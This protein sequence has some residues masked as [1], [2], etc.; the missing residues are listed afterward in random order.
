VAQL[1]SLGGIA[2]MTKSDFISRQTALKSYALKLA[3]TH[4]AGLACFILWPEKKGPDGLDHLFVFCFFSYL[5]VGICLVAW[6]QIRR[7]RQLRA[8]CPKCK[9]R[10]GPKSAQVVLATGKC[11]SCGERILDDFPAA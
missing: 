9:K 5:F 3:M 6:L 8:C 2:L 7:Q 11:G 1:W 4:L 10:F